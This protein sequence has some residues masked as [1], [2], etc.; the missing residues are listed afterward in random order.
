MPLR[1]AISTFYVLKS[2][3]PEL[4]DSS[5][6]VLEAA[7]PDF[8]GLSCVSTTPARSKHL[9]FSFFPSSTQRMR[10]TID[11]VTG[12]GLDARQ[13]KND[14]VLKGIKE[15]ASRVPT[16]WEPY[17]KAGPC[18]IL[19]SLTS[20]CEAVGRKD[21]QSVSHVQSLGVVIHCGRRDRQFVPIGGYRMHIGER[22]GHF[23][24]Q[25]LEFILLKF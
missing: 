9:C 12:P 16:G 23:I 15:A 4:E 10:W 24:C 2:A 5:T 20:S 25:V 11:Y 14:A 3:V 18:V 7:L 17:P 21:T 6:P 22:Y 19:E 13:P 8:T 1:T